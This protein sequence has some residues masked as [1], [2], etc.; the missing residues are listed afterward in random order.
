MIRNLLRAAFSL[1]VF[2]MLSVA[3]LWPLLVGDDR[4]DPWLRIVTLISLWIYLISVAGLLYLRGR[5]S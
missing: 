1:A 2:G 3:F 5:A 4:S